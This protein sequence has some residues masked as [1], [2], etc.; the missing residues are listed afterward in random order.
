MM[1]SIWLR[2][3]ATLT[4]EKSHYH[5]IESVFPEPFFTDNFDSR[6]KSSKTRK[7]QNP[8]I[9]RQKEQQEF[10]D[11]T[12][13]KNDDGSAYPSPFKNNKYYGVTYDFSLNSTQPQ[14]TLLETLNKAFRDVL[15]HAATNRKKILYKP[16]FINKIADVVIPFYAEIR[17]AINDP[18][19][20][21]NA[22]SVMLDVVGVCFV[23]AQ[24][25]T[26]A[27]SMLKNAKGSAKIIREGNQKGLFGKGLQL[28]DIK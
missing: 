15:S 12:L 23:A 8:D 26:K 24:A 22:T 11:N 13:Y 27:T 7:Y 16:T 6:N 5:G 1:D 3:I 28:N 2:K 19:H 10:I 9:R 25:G 21:V 17:G 20:Q 18:E 4:P 14:E